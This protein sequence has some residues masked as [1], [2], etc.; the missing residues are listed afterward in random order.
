MNDLVATVRYVAN[1]YILTTTPGQPADVP[2]EQY[3]ATISEVV[4]WIDR[5]F[6]PQEPATT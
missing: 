2:P 4:F 3:V 1:G 5:I 6:A